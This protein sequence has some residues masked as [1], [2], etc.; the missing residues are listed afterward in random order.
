MHW[1][2]FLPVTGISFATSSYIP[3]N[4][5]AFRNIQVGPRPFYLVEDMD[6][7]P[8]K[9]QL[10]RCSERPIHYAPAFSI[11]HRGA[12]LQ[13]PEHSREGMLAAAREGAGIIEC[14]V[15]VT[16]DGRLVCRH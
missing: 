1:L 6:D 14:D 9:S 2:L 5:P 15:T 16:Q 11:S 7:S 4:V 12:P 8:L 3:D 10:S 13:F